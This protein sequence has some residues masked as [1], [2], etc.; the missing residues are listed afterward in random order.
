MLY[1]E[2]FERR[3]L[4]YSLSELFVPKAFTVIIDEYHWFLLQNTQNKTFENPTIPRYSLKNWPEELGLSLWKYALVKI[5]Y[6]VKSLEHQNDQTKHTIC[7]FFSIFPISSH[8]HFK[9]DRVWKCQ[10]VTLEIL[11]LK[12][13]F[14]QKRN[15]RTRIRMAQWLQRIISFFAYW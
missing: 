3:N 9:M 8:F 4:W 12:E 14:R 1:F 11:N 5:L 10:G 13:L 2:S 15:F 7:I 6:R